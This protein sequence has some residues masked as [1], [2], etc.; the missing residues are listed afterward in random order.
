MIY[1]L[2]STDEDY[3]KIG[4]T[5]NEK[6]L[7]ERI[8]AHKVGN[9]HELQMMALYEGDMEL[10][11]ELHTEWDFKHVRGEWFIWEDDM[12]NLTIG[13]G[14]LLELE[15]TRKLLYSKHLDTA[16]RKWNR[17]NN[18]AQERFNYPIR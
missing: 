2:K 4:Y 5:K 18:V 16:E 15:P 6:S 9:P 3:V 11:K 14:N 10:E 7:K 13:E 1:F 17:R 8:I 12:L